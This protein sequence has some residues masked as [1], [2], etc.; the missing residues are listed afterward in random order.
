MSINTTAHFV[1]QSKGGT[2]KSLCSM[3]LAQYLNEKNNTLKI[4]STGPFHYTLDKYKALDV[5]KIKSLNKEGKLNQAA[6]DKLINKFLSNKKSMLV[7]TSS[8]DFYPLV[9]TLQKMKYLI[10]FQAT[11]K[12]LLS[13]AQ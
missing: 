3:L 10:Y 13:I 8:V 9:I 4:I 5:E 12:I 7:D 11:T 6:L 2:G 1:M